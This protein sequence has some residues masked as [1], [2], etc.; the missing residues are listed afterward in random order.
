MAFLHA[1]RAR[2]D[3]R[4]TTLL[5]FI[6]YIGVVGFILSAATMFAGEFV[7][8]QAKSA[9]IMEV[10]RNA[11]FAAARVAV[12]VRESWG[13]KTASSVFSPTDPG[14][15]TLCTDAP[16]TSNLTVFTVTNGQLTMQQGAGAA[17][18]LTSSKVKVTS[19]LLDNLSTGVKTQEVRIHIV[20][21]YNATGALVTYNQSATG[22]TTAK[23]NKDHGFGP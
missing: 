7:L 17:V 20:A 22:E 4:G 9:A 1:R 10:S 11:R 15:L 14:T 6:I 8:T 5:E 13:I 2:T 18:P 3:E 16:C 21:A 12:A 19:F 23:V